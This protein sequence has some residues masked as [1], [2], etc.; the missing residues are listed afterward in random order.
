M[1]NLHIMNCLVVLKDIFKNIIS[2][3]YVGVLSLN[4]IVIFIILTY[5]F[6]KETKPNKTNLPFI[7]KLFIVHYPTLFLF[8]M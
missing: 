3:Q 4:I 1:Q 7:F 2:G 5:Y 6:T 8:I